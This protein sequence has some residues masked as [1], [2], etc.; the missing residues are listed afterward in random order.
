MKFTVAMKLATGFASILALMIV[1]TMVVRQKSLEIRRVETL[2]LT[3]TTPSYQ[4][5][6]ALQ[7]DLNVTQARAREAILSGSNVQRSDA[8]WTRYAGR[9]EEIKGELPKLRKNQETFMKLAAG[10]EKDAVIRAGDQ[11]T[12]VCTKDSLA[13]KKIV[14]AMSGAQKDLIDTSS[15]KLE[16]LQDSLQ[17]SQTE[18]TIAAIFAGCLVAFWVSRIITSAT[19]RVL[20]RA[21]AISKGD[22]SGEPLAIN[23]RD[24]LGD[25]SEAVNEMQTNLR[26]M[27]A[28]VSTSA[29][30]IAAAS[31]ELSATSAEQASGAETQKNQTQ[32]V[33]TAMLE[34]SS[35]VQ[36][37]SENSNRAAEASRKAAETATRGGVIV[38]GTL[39]KM[40]AI[41][42]SVGKTATVIQELGDCS[43]QIEKIVRL[44]ENIANQTN[45][46]AFNAAIEAARAGE[47]GRGFAIVAGEVRALADRTT[48][49]T[50]EIAGTIAT[51]QSKTK[52]AVEAMQTGTKHVELGVEST[53]QAG[54]ALREIIQM[55]GQ[56]GDM[57][58]LIATAATEQAS[59]TEEINLN[60]E[61]IAKITQETANGA[62][63][64]AKAVH[65]L[66]ALATE[67][68]AMV[69]QFKIGGA[70]ENGRG[71]GTQYRN[72]QLVAVSDERSEHEL[73]EAKAL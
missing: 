24:E 17:K 32:Q 13:I 44:I 45:L 37:V 67:L 11:F 21:R 9:L 52:Y 20:K 56:V 58:M 8:A 60:I 27:I 63:E 6:T 5:S 2:I 16:N 42:D 38:E 53:A 15:V 68:D 48:K 4:L 34:M 49:A 70:P 36:E 51:I 7:R 59:A 41:A 43:S 40:R 33:A 61:Q 71:T 26:R 29:S 64:S 14:D 46:L 1:T 25:L 62:N 73:V 35:T 50:Q 47:Q 28:S 12:D 22:L 72:P 57:V 18:T 10:R 3:V 66:S 65:D 30:R 19:S 69:G 23:T 55:S 39:A 31:E 54:G